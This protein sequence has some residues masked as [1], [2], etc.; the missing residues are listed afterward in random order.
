MCFGDCRH[1][2]LCKQFIDFEREIFLLTS[3]QISIFTYLMVLQD[4][5]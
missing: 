3:L 2:E 4:I 1:I 5:Y